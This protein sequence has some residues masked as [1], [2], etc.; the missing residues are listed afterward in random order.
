MADRISDLPDGVLCHVL[1]FLPT[2][3]AI[4]TTILSK[5]WNA[6]WR[7][8]PSLTFDDSDYFFN[9]TSQSYSRFVQCVHVAILL[10]DWHQ[11][12]RSFRLRVRS[13]L[14]DY[15]NVTVWINTVVQRGVQ[16]LDLC[17]GN[18]FN[19]PSAV[20]TCKTLVVLKLEK[21]HIK[22]IPSFDFPLLKI[23]HLINLYFSEHRDFAQLV[24]ASPNLE[25]LEV[26][27]MFIHCRK[28]EGSFDYLPKLVRATVPKVDVPLGVVSN[29]QFLRLDWMEQKLKHMD[30]NRRVTVFRNLIHLELGYI[31]SIQDWVE[32]FQIL[33]CS[34]NLQI[35]VIDKMY[36]DP[37]PLANREA[38]DWIYPEF[39]PV[40]ISLNL[41]RCCFKN[42]RGWRGELGF[43][44][45]IMGNAEQLQTMSIYSNIY[46]KEDQKFKMIKELSLCTRRSACCKLI[47]E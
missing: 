45:Y 34:P 7:T 13:S 25:E 18:L 12:V 9:S 27:D 33:K 21:F 46:T 14:C 37:L 40:G 24:R 44:E 43:V 3:A 31:N 20:P 4:A 23:M 28:V 6:L 10:R 16:H 1:S 42:Y 8:C 38:A 22:N 11:T 26:L 35:F 39:V 19:L 41:R 17:V 47:F 15:T 36:L 30:P 2:T 32:V 5:R 29:V